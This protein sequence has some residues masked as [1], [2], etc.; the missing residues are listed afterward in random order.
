MQLWEWNMLSAKTLIQEGIKNLKWSEI[1]SVSRQN[2]VGGT[3]FTLPPE[4]TQKLDKA[5]GKKILEILEVGRGVTVKSWEAGN[6][7][8]EDSRSAYWLERVSRWWCREQRHGQ[9]P[10]ELPTPGRQVD[11]AGRVCRES[12]G[13][14]AAVQKEMP[15]FPG[16]FIW[17]LT[18]KKEWR[19][20][21]E[22]LERIR[23]HSAWGSHGAEKSAY[24]QLF[25]V[26]SLSQRAR[27][28]TN[29]THRVSLR[30]LRVF[31]LSQ[32]KLTID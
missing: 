31:C 17:V 10:A 11:E 21:Q 28:R 23:R 8:S 2:G 26:H 7:W 14:R 4:I 29:P 19:P 3:R 18:K 9:K 15:H 20:G 1:T 5:Y 22:P 27:E 16:A 25:P 30:A 6:R 13:Q 24:C 12:Q 32:E